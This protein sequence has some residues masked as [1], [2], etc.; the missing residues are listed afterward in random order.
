MIFII[1]LALFYALSRRKNVKD[2]DSCQGFL[3]RAD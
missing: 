2:Y 1:G 3:K